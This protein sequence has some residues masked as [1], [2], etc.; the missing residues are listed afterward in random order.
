MVVTREQLLE[1]QQAYFDAE[2][3]VLQGKSITLNGQSMTMESLGDI[4]KGRQE[5]EDRLR[6]MD[7][8]RN[9]YSLAR[10]S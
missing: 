2:L 1:L 4:R 7:N 8:P 9:L 3:A 6:Q 10:F 5:I